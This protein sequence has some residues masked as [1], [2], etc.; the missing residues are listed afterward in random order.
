MV[1]TK[2]PPGPRSVVR[3]ENFAPEASSMTSAEAVI[4]CRSFPRRS[5]SPVAD[6]LTDLCGLPSYII[7]RPA[8]PTSLRDQ[9][10]TLHGPP[11]LN[12]LWP[13]RMRGDKGYRVAACPKGNQREART[14]RRE[15]GCRARAAA[16]A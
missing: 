6:L 15:A 5:A 12:P 9:L 4:A 13:C 1:S 10:Q 3:V 7:W 11:R 14:A 8:F 2:H 16:D